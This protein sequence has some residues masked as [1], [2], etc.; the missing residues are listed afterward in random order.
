MATNIILQSE[1]RLF[2]SYEDIMSKPSH[3]P[4]SAK[5]LTTHRRQSC[6]GGKGGT[7]LRS[8]EKRGLYTCKTSQGVRGLWLHHYGRNPSPCTCYMRLRTLVQYIETDN[9]VTLS[10]PRETETRTKNQRGWGEEGW[11]QWVNQ[12]GGGGGGGNELKEVS[13]WTKDT[14]YGTQYRNSFPSTPP[15]QRGEWDG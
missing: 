6:W 11:W 12:S 9:R 15:V 14:V 3:T 8:E 1:V 10:T 13:V 2:P 7:G 5:L 4:C